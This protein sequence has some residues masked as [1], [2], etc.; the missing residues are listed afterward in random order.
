MDMLID[1]AS[2]QNLNKFQRK[3]QSWKTLSN[4]LNVSD[5]NKSDFA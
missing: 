1:I 3:G 2:D 5:N 4:A